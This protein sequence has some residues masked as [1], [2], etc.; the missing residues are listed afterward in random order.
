MKVR[1]LQNRVVIQP[2]EPIKQSAGGLIIPDIATEKPET[3]TVLAVGAGKR[4]ENNTLIPMSVEV[5]DV[6]IFSKGIGEKVKIDGQE[7]IVVREDDLIG[8]IK[9]ND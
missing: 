7:Y 4:L 3:G 6:V 9:Q 1:P 5:G 2:T 8:V